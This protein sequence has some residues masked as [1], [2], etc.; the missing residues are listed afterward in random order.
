MDH[1]GYNVTIPIPF[2]GTYSH[3]NNGY[4]Q[5]YSISLNNMHGKV[6]SVA[7][8]ANFNEPLRNPGDPGISPIAA[9]YYQYK[10]EGKFIRNKATGNKLDN[11]VQILTGDAL[12]STTE[13]GKHIDTYV[14]MRENKTTASSL[15]LALQLDFTPP[16]LFVP[17]GIPSVSSTHSMFRGVATN[18]VITRNG[19]LEKQVTTKEGATSITEN[20][21]YDAA[22]GSPLLTTTTN[23]F[24][25]PI[26]DYT[27]A[28]H[29]ENEGMEG[30][31][32]NV[33]ASGL[34]LGSPLIH[35]GDE[36]LAGTTKYWVEND[37]TL[38]NAAGSPAT[39]S[40]PFKIIRSG[41]RNQQAVKSGNIVSL[42]NPVAE[43]IF[44][45][46]TTINSLVLASPGTAGTGVNLMPNSTAF[47]ECFNDEVYGII[48]LSVV[49]GCPNKL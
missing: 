15:G 8:Y 29:W 40:G 30:A 14:A 7:T 44:P 36:L 43:R 41:Y 32:Q 3:H 33:G 9:T 42:T 13:I 31:Y 19:I 5:G 34:S 18:K 47:D 10:T 27:Y 12:V 28:A 38:V 46:F 4:S 22:T 48:A 17:T 1:A 45:L 39:S 16:F 2:I 20:L 11:S 26:Y 37:G 25:A 35:P 21:Y 6:Y 23:D 24:D 49:T